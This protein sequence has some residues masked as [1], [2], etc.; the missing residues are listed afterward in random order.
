MSTK[1]IQIL[2]Y[3]FFPTEMDETLQYQLGMGW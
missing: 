3:I 1:V 2:N